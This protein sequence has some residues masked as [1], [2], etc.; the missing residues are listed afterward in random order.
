MTLNP[1]GTAPNAAPD[2]EGRMRQALGLRGDQSNPSF[3]L[4][5]AAKSLIER[6]M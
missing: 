6:A 2:E 4:P 3:L 1:F 5:V